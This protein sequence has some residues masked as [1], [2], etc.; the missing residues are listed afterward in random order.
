MA[1]D[2]NNCR[3][4]VKAPNAAS[5]LAI[6][7]SRVHRE[8]LHVVELVLHLL[9]FEEGLILELRHADGVEQM[10]V[11]GDVHRLDVR[12]R[13][14]HHQ[15]LGGFEHLR[16][17]LHVA[18]VHLDI[19]LSEEPEDL[20]QQVPLGRAQVPVP[21]LDIVGQRH[22]L[23]QPMDTLLGEPRLIGPGVAE[24][25]V[26]RVLSQQI[27]PHR[28]FVGGPDRA[29]HAA[30]PCRALA[31]SANA[32]LA[33]LRWLLQGVTAHLVATD[34]DSPICWAKIAP[35]HDGGMG[36]E[37]RGTARTRHSAPV[38]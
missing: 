32:Q 33:R 4:S 11:G 1:N 20:C 9:V 16:V 30:S 13:R 34:P 15:H 37:S 27:E 31:K 5:V 12:E 25:L 6:S 8:C 23:R 29:V 17:M 28:M 19:G 7:N 35:P 14:Q 38:N 26:D 10:A 21:I 18:V 36:Q 3:P 22:F 2:A 24:R